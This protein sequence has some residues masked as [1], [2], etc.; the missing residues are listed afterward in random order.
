M[1]GRGYS[2]LGREHT[3]TLEFPDSLESQII[4]NSIF[5]LV[6]AG[7]IFGVSGQI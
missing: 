5:L 4:H 3:F 1:T 2:D 6:L 7:L